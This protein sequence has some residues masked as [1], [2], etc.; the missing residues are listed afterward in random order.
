MF[1]RLSSRLST[2]IILVCCLVVL[3]PVLVAAQDIP[4]PDK[5]LD[6]LKWLIGEWDV[7]YKKYDQGSW[8]EYKAHST[9]EYIM[10]DHAVAQAMDVIREQN[11]KAVFRTLSYNTVS[12]QFEDT[13][14]STYDDGTS[15]FYGTFANNTYV[16]YNGS[17]L[18]KDYNPGAEDYGIRDTMDKI[19]ENSFTWHEEETHDGGETWEP[20]LVL[21]FTRVK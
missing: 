4:A 7:V 19:T 21:E 6:D 16:A 5:H 3:V 8:S 9:F 18:D 15:T 10:H 17:F 13:W 2:L 14:I 12:E 11:P 1:T 20:F